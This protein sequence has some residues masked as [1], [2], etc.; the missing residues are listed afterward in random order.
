MVGEIWTY[1][2][3]KSNDNMVKVRPVLVIGNEKSNELKLVDIHYVI[4]SSSAS[5]GKYDI[6]L[7]SAVAK[8][9]GLDRKSVIKTT[10]IYTGSKDKLGKKIGELPYEIKNQF[11]NNYKE[12]QLNLI[13]NFNEKVVS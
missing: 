11:I 4:V 3:T 1:V 5:V 2:A 9:I 13:M 12:Y 8:S 6:E 10:K 7:N